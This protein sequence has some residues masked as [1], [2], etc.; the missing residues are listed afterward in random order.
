MSHSPPYFLS[1]N[2]EKTVAFYSL[3]KPRNLVIFIHGFNGGAVSTWDD[4]SKLIYDHDRFE[5]TDVIFYGYPSLKQQANN[6]AINF[7]NFLIESSQPNQDLNDCTD[8]AITNDDEY[9]N[10]VLVA[11]SLGAVVVRRA[12]LFIKGQGNQNTLL[13]KT[14]MLLFAPA[15]KGT[16]IKTSYISGLPSL[17]S[18]V[19][20]IGIWK[21]P[22][23]SN[24]QQN[25]ATIVSLINDTQ[26][27]IDI[28]DAEFTV[29]S[30]VIWANADNVVENDTFGNDPEAIVEDGTH[31]SICKPKNN[32]INPLNYLSEILM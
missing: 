32:Y 8:R 1:P 15:H 17:L 14:K 5:K 31:T 24:L 22:S 30:K 4:F 7:K 27:Y 6:N 25:S 28:G 23:F 11:H 9:E 21:T 10:V 26:R 16:L 12:L 19:G 3:K 29:A 2:K 20:V 18:L 13:E